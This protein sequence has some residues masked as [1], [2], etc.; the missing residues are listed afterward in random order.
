MTSVTLKSRSIKNPGI[1]LSCILLSRNWYFDWSCV[2]WQKLGIVMRLHEEIKLGHFSTSP[3]SQE[4]KSYGADFWLS[5]HLTKGY[6][7]TK[8]RVDSPH[9]CSYETWET[10]LL[11]RHTDGPTDGCLG[12]HWIAIW[13][14]QLTKVNWAKKVMQIQWINTQQLHAYDILF[15]RWQ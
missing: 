12:R 3:M 6:F 10:C 13:Q 15:N 14:A 1:I 11:N 2:K 7:L 8:Q 4:K 5:G 9:T